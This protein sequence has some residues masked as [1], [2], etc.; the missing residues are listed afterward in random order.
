MRRV[1]RVALALGAAA[2]GAVAFGAVAIGA[3]AVGRARVRRLEV[4]EVE[5]GRLRVRELVLP[6]SEQ[7]ATPGPSQRPRARRGGGRTGRRSR[8]STGP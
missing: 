7:G 4:E 6:G 2:L 3:L 8:P 1:A 5:I